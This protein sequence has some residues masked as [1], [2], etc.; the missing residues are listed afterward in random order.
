MSSVSPIPIPHTT[1][2]R[3]VSDSYLYLTNSSSASRSRS[4]Q[5]KRIR[6]RSSV[7]R[8][9]Q[10]TM[11]KSGFVAVAPQ[12]RRNELPSG[13]WASEDGLEPEQ[14]QQHQE[15]LELEPEELTQHQHVVAP[16]SPLHS[17]REPSAAIRHH[18]GSREMRGRSWG[19]VGV[20][21][22]PASTSSARMEAEEGVE[23]E[24]DVSGLRSAF[25]HSDDDDGEYY[26]EEQDEPAAVA[27]YDDEEADDEDDEERTAAA[28]HEQGDLEEM[29]VPA[30]QCGC[31]VPHCH[32]PSH[33]EPHRY[34]SPIPMH[35]HMHDQLDFGLDF[36]L[37]STL[38]EGESSRP[39]PAGWARRAH[40][41]VPALASATR[42]WA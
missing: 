32:P 12:P 7:R 35:I 24:Y 30:E 8:A 17:F 36:D 18:G 13:F 3:S 40:L 41:L 34:R 38:A 31:H 5:N 10:P 1:A 39:R 15:E 25:E 27:W 2:R 11:M 21:R 33:Y 14:G 42:G 26:G 20:V 4:S 19:R 9:Y 28:P 37:N 23:L 6:G 16:L 29:P 22:A